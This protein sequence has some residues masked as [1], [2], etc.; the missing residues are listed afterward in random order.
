MRLPSLYVLDPDAKRERR[1]QCEHARLQAQ[2]WRFRLP[3]L[4]G[5]HC[6]EALN[7]A[8]LVDWRGASATKDDRQVFTEKPPRAFKGIAARVTSCRNADAGP[9]ESLH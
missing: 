1:L 8:L 3:R 4:G 9:N 2:L 6:F 7:G 5:K